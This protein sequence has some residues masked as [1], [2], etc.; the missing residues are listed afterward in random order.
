MATCVSMAQLVGSD[1]RRGSAARGDLRLLLRSPPCL[2]FARRPSTVRALLSQME[3][4]G[5]LPPPRV[6]PNRSLAGT[7]ALSK[8]ECPSLYRLCE[9]L[10]PAVMYSGTG[11]SN[12]PFK[13]TSAAVHCSILRYGKSAHST[14]IRFGWRADHSS[15]FAFVQARRAATNCM[16]ASLMTS[17]RGVL[18]G[19]ARF[20]VFVPT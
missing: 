9:I 14:R 4:H 20:L 7:G 5:A 15:L 11:T 17:Q 3:S 6:L 13:V 12:P 8:E 16:T 18:R 19:G 1:V 2:R 10:G